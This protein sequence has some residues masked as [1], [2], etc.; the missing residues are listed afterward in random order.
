[1]LI[2]QKSPSLPRNLSLE[3]FGELQIVFSTQLNLL[4]LLSSMAWIHCLLHLIKQ[5]YLLKAFLRTHI[6]D[7]SGMSLPV[8]LAGTIL[9]FQHISVTPKIVEKVITNLDSSKASH[10]DCILVVVLNNWAT[11]LIHITELFNT[12]LK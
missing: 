4:C 1:M 10:P 6:F 3:T 11:T 5:N 7:N 2:K 8:F 12:C 9:K